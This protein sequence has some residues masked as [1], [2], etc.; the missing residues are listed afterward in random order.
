[1]P[2]AANKIPRVVNLSS[3][4]AQLDHGVG[5]VSRLHDIEQTINAVAANVTHLR[6]GAFMENVLMSIETIESAGAMHLPIRG[7]AK[8][9][10]ATRDIAEAAASLLLDG[11]WSGRRAVT[12]YG[13]EGLSH[14]DVAT[15]LTEILGK[16]VNHVEVTPE[17]ARQA[18]LKMGLTANLVRLLLELYDA[19]STGRIV[20]GLPAK[21]D[22]RGTT[23]FRELATTV[24][25]PLLGRA[26]GGI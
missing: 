13:P 22:L 20:R 11:T 21:P 7:A 12:L 18:M 24:V 4:G 26:R 25:K 17:Q 23:T 8:V 19:I 15:V 14:G 6:P 5:P 16:P 10:M 1:M 3:V 2:L 9:P